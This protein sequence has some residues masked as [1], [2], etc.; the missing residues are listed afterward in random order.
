MV[1]LGEFRVSIVLSRTNSDFVICV[2]SPGWGGS[3]RDLLRALQHLPGSCK[4]VL[5]GDILCETLRARFAAQGIQI[6]QHRVR[7]RLTAAVWGLR[8]A[9]HLIDRFPNARFLVWAHHADSH[10]WLQVALAWRRANFVVAERLLPATEAE[11]KNSIS[12]KRI[13]Q[14]V[15]NRAHRI[16]LCGYS[17]LENYHT[18][19]GVEKSRLLAVVNSR[20]VDQIRARVADLRLDRPQLR[21]S[22]GLPN[23]I[24]V[25]NL[26]RLS[27]GQKDQET[28][29]RAIG[30][31]RAMGH[32][33]Q[34]LLVGSGSDEERLRQLATEMGSGS[35]TFAGEQSDPLPWLAASD[36]F[37]FPSRSEGLPGALLEA[38]AAGL[39][40]VA[41]AI[42]GN[43]ELVRHEQTGLLFPVG[44][45]GRLA[46]VLAR[47]IADQNLADRMAAAGHKFVRERYDESIEIAGWRD[48]FGCAI[49]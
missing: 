46:A 5:C 47:Y 41:T 48:I 26:A 25:V 3:E 40:C 1:G 18:W 34:L 22:L 12:R 11:A 19:F 39:P 29:I 6:I 2:D 14:W 33:V 16:A 8:D 10:R 43:C 17:Q 24:I 4:A 32:S 49:S 20:P 9:L 31:L 35:V 23:G 38:M 21:K 44:D 27:S 42:P 37:G 36:I 30:R 15:G 28:L 45:A 13:K 7:N